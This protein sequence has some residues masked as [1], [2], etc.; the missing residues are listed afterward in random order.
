MAQLS[1]STK[2]L[3]KYDDFYKH[4]WQIV[5]KMRKEDANENFRFDSVKEYE[6]MFTLLQQIGNKAENLNIR[7]IS[8][9]F[10]SIL[11]YTKKIRS[12]ISGLMTLR[13][14]IQNQAMLRNTIVKIENL[15]L[16]TATKK[17]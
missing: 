9:F 8:D 10:M 7:D 12:K 1:R 15:L 17:D 11:L 16:L 4:S 5:R 6:T 2:K 14:R 3:K 13:L